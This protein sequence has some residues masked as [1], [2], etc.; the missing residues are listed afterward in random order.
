MTA[1]VTSPQTAA[2]IM[3]RGI[4]SVEVTNSLQDAM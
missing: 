3:S 4:V 1:N 2:S